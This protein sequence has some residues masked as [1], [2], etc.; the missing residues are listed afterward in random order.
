MNKRQ[1][2][3]GFLSWAERMKYIE[4]FLTRRSFSKLIRKFSKPACALCFNF[5]RPVS[6]FPVFPDKRALGGFSQILALILH[7]IETTGGYTKTQP[8]QEPEMLD[9]SAERVFI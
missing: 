5:G 6:L 9:G 7:S 3:N 4:F 8:S 2:V 1:S